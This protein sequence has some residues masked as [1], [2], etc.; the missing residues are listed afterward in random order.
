VPENKVKTIGLLGGMNW[1]SSARSVVAISFPI[2]H[3]NV[4]RVTLKGDAAG[5]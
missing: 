3:V 2:V 4:I 5:E 1:A